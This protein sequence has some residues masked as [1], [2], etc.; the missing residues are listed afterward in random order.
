MTSRA[1]GMAAAVA[2]PALSGT[3]VG[4]GVD[5]YRLAIDAPH[6]MSPG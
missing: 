3:I 1:P 2:R 6:R 4:L 5:G